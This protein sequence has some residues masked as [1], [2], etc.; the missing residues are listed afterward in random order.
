MR[1][2]PTLF[3]RRVLDA[4]VGLWFCATIASVP[5]IIVLPPIGIAMIGVMFGLL[6]LLLWPVLWYTRRMSERAIAAG[7]CPGCGAPDL[8]YVNEGTNV[9]YQC[10]RCARKFYSNGKDRS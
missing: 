8:P 7:R 5:L 4:G 6:I 3:H 2:R 1:M 9:G 10:G